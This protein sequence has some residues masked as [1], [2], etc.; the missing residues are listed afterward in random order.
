MQQGSW[1]PSV[2]LPG[3]S[4]LTY[5][6]SNP[7]PL[8]CLQVAHALGFGAIA[9]D[10]VGLTSL[11]HLGA[12]QVSCD[13]RLAAPPHLASTDPALRVLKGRAAMF[14]GD[15]CQHEQPGGQPAYAYAKDLKENPTFIPSAPAA[16]IAA[17]GLAAAAGPA[18][19]ADRNNASPA[20]TAPNDAQAPPRWASARGSC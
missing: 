18:T 12:I 20:S 19:G 2:R 15:P 4:L 10:E 9:I 1:E 14:V 17:P 13:R 3:H 16:K 8:P 6:H 11:A 5:V 7:S